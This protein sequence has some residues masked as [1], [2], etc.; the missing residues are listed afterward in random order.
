MKV[1]KV[2]LAVLTIFCLCLGGLG[3]YLSNEKPIN[4]DYII[5]YVYSID[6]ARVNSMPENIGMYSFDSYVC[7]N[8]VKGEW[9]EAEWKFIPSVTDNSVC[10]L[11]FVTKTFDVQVEFENA[12]NND[13]EFN[14][15]KTIKKG[16]SIEFDLTPTEGYG[17]GYVKCSNDETA[18]FDKTTNKLLIGP[19]TA[20]SICTVNFK[21]NEYK[22][23]VNATNAMPGNASVT[24]E[25]GKTAEVEIAPT[26][27]YT[28]DS[29]ECTNDMKASWASNKLKIDKVTSDTECTLKFKLQSYKVSVSVTGGVVDS[30][31]KK[32]AYGKSDSFTIT[33][34]DSH[35]LDEATVECGDNAEGSISLNKLTVSNI[36]GN[37]SCKVTLKAKP[38]EQLE[39]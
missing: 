5:D 30:A 2:I 32:I 14:G 10:E 3:F 13:T 19:F 6:N 22:V 38:E 12:K 8:N 17:F 21:I 16:E 24:V 4:K 27:N 26:T 35:T 31:S 36:K 9:N 37:A 29:V 18:S 20:S 15:T 33:A 7:T 39:N 25:H 28:F 11:Y 34:D 1:A 23:N